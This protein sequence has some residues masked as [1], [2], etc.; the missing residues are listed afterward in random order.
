MICAGDSGPACDIL[1]ALLLALRGFEGLAEG[2]A[3]MLRP[4]M[5]VALKPFASDAL[6]NASNSG[7]WSRGI[8]RGDAA[9]VERT[10]EVG[11]LQFLRECWPPPPDELCSCVAESRVKPK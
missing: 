3:P 9:A 1:P 5:R 11:G 4:D 6:L 2:S 8:T 7:F 10:F